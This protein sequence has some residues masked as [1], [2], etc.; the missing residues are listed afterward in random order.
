SGRPPWSA[1]LP[2][3]AA[4]EPTTPKRLTATT[5]TIMNSRDR[6]LMHL[7]ARACPET[8]PRRHHILA[9]DPDSGRHPGPATHGDASSSRVHRRG[10]AGG[11][12]AG[13]PEGRPGRPPVARRGGQLH[14]VHES[15]LDF[16]GGRCSLWFS[17]APP[18]QRASGLSPSW[19]G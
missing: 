3:T 11:G 8:R 9:V 5:A 18:S 4:A 17:D 6:I 2:R 10:G 15:A 1:S 16:A 19:F 14:L 7:Q 12:P 13:T